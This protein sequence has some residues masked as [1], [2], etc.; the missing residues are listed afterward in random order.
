[1]DKQITQ[2]PG[3]LITDTSYNNQ[4]AGSHRFA[5]NAINETISGDKGFISNEKGS[6][7][8]L[9]LNDYKVIGSISLL[10]NEN[11]LFLAKEDGSNSK[12]ALQ[13]NC[14]LTP[15]VE[16]PCLNFSTKHPITGISKIRKGCN[17]V[18]YFRD[19]FNSDR[20]IDIDVIL[21]NPFDNIYYDGTWKCKLFK[22]SM[23][24]EYPCLTYIK[25]NNSGGNLKLGTYQFSVALGDSNLN[26][27]HP[28]S[29]TQPIPIISGQLYTNN[30]ALEGGE[31][32]KEINTTKSINISISNLDT[33]FQYIKLYA[34]ESID[35]VVTAYEIETLP[36]NDTVI[37]YTYSGIDYSA[38]TIVDIAIINNI[39]A[40]Y[41]NSKSMEQHDQRLIRGNL[42]EKQISNNIWQQAANAIKVRYVTKPIKHVN[43]NDVFSGDYYADTRSYMRDEVYALSISGVFSNGSTTAEF[44]IPGRN[45]D[46]DWNNNP[47]PSNSDPQGLFGSKIHNRKAPI[48]GWDSTEYIVKDVVTYPVISGGLQNW[49]G[50]KLNENIGDPFY[51]LAT[52]EV[53]IEDCRPLNK[54]A[55]DTI[56][57][58]ELF[59][60]AYVTETNTVND[61]YYTKGQLAYW[62]STYDYPD[63][64]DCK[65]KRVFP[66]GK[67][68]H[69]KMPDSTLEKHH[70]NAAGNEYI[71]PLGLDFDISDFKTYLQANLSSAEYD[72][73]VGY[74]ISRSKRDKGNKSVIDKGIS[75][76][77]V[78]MN[79][80][81]NI[82]GEFLPNEQY[83]FQTSF[84]NKNAEV[85]RNSSEIRFRQFDN[86]VLGSVTDILPHEDTWESDPEAV[87]GGVLKHSYN[88]MHILN[89]KSQYLNDN[90]F[91]Y[92]KAEREIY[93]KI[94]AWGD[95]LSWD[96][97]KSRASF[98][99]K[100]TTSVNNIYKG[101]PMPNFTNRI[102]FNN[103]LLEANEQKVFDERTVINNTQQF[104]QLAKLDNFPD[105][106]GEGVAYGGSPGHTGGSQ[107]SSQFNYSNSAISNQFANAY[108]IAL[109]NY[110]PSQ[111]G[112]LNN[113]TYYPI[114][115]CLLTTDTFTLFG[116]DIFI[117]EHTF[118]KTYIDSTFID[119]D[120]KT[121]WTTQISYFV[122]SEI[123][124]KLRHQ[125]YPPT[126]ESWYYPYHGTTNDKI[127]EVMFKCDEV[128][129]GSDDEGTIIGQYVLGNYCFNQFN[130]NISYSREQELKPNFGLPLTYDY[131]SNCANEFPYRIVY[132]EK[133][134]Q[135]DLVDNFKIFPANNYRDLSPNTG[136]IYNVFRESD[137]LYIRTT[138]SCWYIPSKYQELQTGNDAVFIGTGE[139]LSLPPKELTS[140]VNGYN[141]G[142]TSLDLVT[143]EYG[144][145]Y[146][147][148]SSGIV[149][150]LKG[151][152][153]K[154]IIEGNRLW[155]ENNLPFNLLNHTNQ[156][157]LL[158]SPTDTNGIGL[159]G[160]YDATHRRY[161]LTKKD[162]YPIYPDSTV[163]NS[164]DN[165][166]YII[167]NDTVIGVTDA[168][169]SPDY[170]E[171]KSW[172]I[173]YSLDNNAWVSWHS[174]LPNFMYSTRN[175]YYSTINSNTKLQQHLVGNFTTY[176][177]TKYPHIIEY[178]NTENI[179]Q[180]K[181]NDTIQYFNTVS[182][183]D[184]TR[185]YW[186]EIPT[187]TFTN[188]M[189]YND[190]QNTGLVDI[191]IKNSLDPFSSV[192]NT[193]DASEIYAE[194]TETSWS[195]S[196]FRDMVNQTNPTQPIFTSNW[197]DLKTQYFIDKLPNMNVINYLKSQFEMEPL[198][199]NY[200]ACRLYFKP[201]DNQRITTKFLYNTFTNS[202]R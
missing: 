72:D 185:K 167:I 81:F 135:E 145:F 61:T 147:D 47:L 197:D 100:F 95:A 5:L 101:T 50:V 193:F 99:V 140:V 59:N 123:N 48:N 141:G 46:K 77:M 157:S 7:D 163:Y 16:D 151:G 192:L 1:M 194:K 134:Y 115:T 36:I 142:Q 39:P 6:S 182:E 199:D 130:Y 111:Y 106:S 15:I 42:K 105:I 85:N 87:Q 93:N 162:Y 97:D 184:S 178:I 125:S 191:Q 91:N 181:I 127:F 96:D 179:L 143:N 89:P 103:T 152:Q 144:A 131:C 84:F 31:A 122:E 156:F 138:Q 177:G 120:E 159:I 43:N 73:I 75:F 114:N 79:Y 174:Y 169:N 33:D 126:E 9:E 8:C 168:Y 70:V 200:I 40:I 188:G 65:E 198:R 32:S 74:K 148:T 49:N 80:D 153:Q 149:F 113:L 26:F 196:K 38:S 154:S 92:I 56:K 68:R 129:I 11:I 23:E 45:I 58:W 21:K 83:L 2:L 175:Y 124:C 170:F 35:N 78:E 189:F 107:W 117:S 173:S 12:I 90:T 172:T 3:K 71:L 202:T 18:I 63:I 41:D 190:T 53:N 121:W 55:G 186:K 171:N 166:W 10:D 64:I 82:D 102:K 37:N 94:E 4:P 183:Y 28:L 52:N 20:S 195:I 22:L 116:G 60:T 29:V 13:N 57:R 176:Y 25:T 137:Q 139:F 54:E 51:T 201:I 17:R 30:N 132:S 108:Y 158:D 14:F 110:I 19:S 150:Q 118:R 24:F 112:Q 180:T 136:E 98:W 164:I 62:E 161:I 155:F 165:E 104:M 69:H 67:I 133:S 146:A 86:A 187:S 76:R 119:L 88:Y 44:H 66:E 160:V 109:K 34:I 128:K 27:T